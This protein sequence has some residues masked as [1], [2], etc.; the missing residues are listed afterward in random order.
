MHTMLHVLDTMCKSNLFLADTRHYLMDDGSLAIFNVGQYETSFKETTHPL[1]YSCQ[2]KNSITG[3]TKQSQ[4]F[5]L[6]NTWY[7][8]ILMK[9]EDFLFHCSFILLLAP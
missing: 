9:T 5:S 4:P 6:G 7:Q 1:S 2:L 8:K 3:Q